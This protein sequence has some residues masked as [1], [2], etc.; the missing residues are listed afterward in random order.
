[1]GRTLRQHRCQLRPGVRMFLCPVFSVAHVIGPSGLATQ[2]GTLWLTLG[3]N[4]HAGDALSRRWQSRSLVCDFTDGV[5]RRCWNPASLLIGMKQL[6]MPWLVLGYA[7][8]QVVSRGGVAF[9]H[10]WTG[11]TGW[12]GH[13][14]RD[15]CRNVSSRTARSW[16]DRRT[17]SG[18]HY[19][20]P[21]IERP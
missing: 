21:I 20:R 10:G 16:F 11:F 4:F 15:C 12:N 9:W 19:R 5:G 2:H 6:F 13:P 17:M 3:R 1:M 8:W 14:G 7:F 18:S